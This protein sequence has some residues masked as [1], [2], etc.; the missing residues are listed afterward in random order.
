MCQYSKTKEFTILKE[1]MVVYK[2]MSPIWID[3]KTNKPKLTSPYQSYAFT[4]GKTH[5]VTKKGIKNG[6]T[7]FLH[8]MDHYY[9]YTITVGFHS[10]TKE[11]DAIYQAKQWGRS[12][13]K[14]IIPKGSSVI[15]GT[16]GIGD[17][18]LET[19]VSNKIKVIEIIE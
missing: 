16:F 9:P 18:M 11:R 5:T 15:F 1:D 3:L 2:I 6:I 4:L 14:C 13:T 12:L 8:I 10:F 17:S 7:K 19:V